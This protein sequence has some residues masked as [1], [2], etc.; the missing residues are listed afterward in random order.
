MPLFEDNMQ[1]E[2]KILLVGPVIFSMFAMLSLLSELAYYALY[3][4]IVPPEFI[5]DSSISLTDSILRVVLFFSVAIFFGVFWLSIVKYKLTVTQEQVVVKTLFKQHDID[6]HDITTFTF[7][8]VGKSKVFRFILATK[9][10]NYLVLTHYKT[11]FIK[12]LTNSQQSER[13]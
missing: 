1:K 2:S 6:L 5:S 7:K 10:K 9:N 4:P 3:L 8:K 11:E 13:R 12:V